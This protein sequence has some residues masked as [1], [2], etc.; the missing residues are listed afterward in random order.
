MYYWLF[1][2]LFAAVAQ[3]PFRVDPTTIENSKAKNVPNIVIEGKIYSAV[4]P[5]T[6]PFTGEVC[7]CGAATRL[8]LSLFHPPSLR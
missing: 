8:A 4:C 1:E 5:V 6:K 2:M 3:V 7:D